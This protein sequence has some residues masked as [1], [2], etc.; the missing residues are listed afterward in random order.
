MK[1]IINTVKVMCLAI[2]GFSGTCVY[3]VESDHDMPHLHIEYS[4]IRISCGE[5]DFTFIQNEYSRLWQNCCEFFNYC[6]N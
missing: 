5:H 1:N 2:L 6:F 4:P 3:G